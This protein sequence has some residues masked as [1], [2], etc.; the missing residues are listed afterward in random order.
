MN[1]VITGCFLVSMLAV[2]TFVMAQAGD[3]STG[4]LAVT[5]TIASSISLTVETGTVGPTITNAGSN[6]GSVALGTFSKYGAT[7]TGFN[8]TRQATTWTLT[9]DL[10]VKVVQANSTSATY[11]LTGNLEADPLTVVWSLAGTPF[12][13]VASK[14]INATAAYGSSIVYPWTIVIPDALTST[15][16]GNTIHFLATSN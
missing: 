16:I 2:P 11:A 1:K 14:S 15:N 8:K 10:G 6:S 3:T 12:V 9:S 4:T 7:P 5:G 13:A